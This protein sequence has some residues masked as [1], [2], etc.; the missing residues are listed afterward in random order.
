MNGFVYGMRG[1][2]RLK[3]DWGFNN[4]DTHV[5]VNKGNQEPSGLKAIRFSSPVI[6]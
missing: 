5:Q 6:D 3:F 1:L 4:N 2:Y